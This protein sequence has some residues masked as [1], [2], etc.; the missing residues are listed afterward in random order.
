MEFKQVNF[1]QLKP[2]TKYIITDLNGSFYYTGWFSVYLKN[3]KDIAHFKEVICTTPIKR[4][5]GY[6]SFSYEP[7]RKYYTITS[8]KNEIQNA[9]E[10]RSLN[11]IIQTILGES[12]FNYLNI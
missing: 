3:G 2:N 10:M 12:K 1:Y 5:C 11:L 9:M 6:V 8:K 7:G 4:H